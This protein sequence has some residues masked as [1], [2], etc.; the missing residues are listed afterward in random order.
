MISLERLLTNTPI[1][2]LGNIKFYQPT[3]L[4][5]SNM[6]E[7]T[8]WSMLKI[9]DLSRDEI[10][11]KEDESTKKLTDFELWID[12]IFAS[13]PLRMSLASS[14]DCFLH[15]KVE[16]LS[17]SHT[18]IVGE[19]DS[20]TL[21]DEHFYS[22]VND[23]VKSLTSLDSDKEKEQYKETEGMSEREKQMVKKMRENAAKINK[24]KNGDEKVKDRLAN[25]IIALVAIGHYTF[26][27]VYKMT[28]VQLVYLLK[29]YVSIQQYELYTALSPYADSKKSQPIK[30]WLDT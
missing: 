22:T 18:I 13:T 28:I 15:T 19:N 29:K 1:P 23:I 6:G 25:Q 3:L 4:E 17:V 2:I 26:D 9:W 11:T 30:H 7:N 12:S 8:Y 5:I 16:F 10:I 27:D 24:I 21:V 14:I 20:L